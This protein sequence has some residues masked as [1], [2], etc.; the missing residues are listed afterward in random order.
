LVRRDDTLSLAGI[1]HHEAPGSSPQGQ[2]L[3]SLALRVVS[4][5]SLLEALKA[6]IRDLDAE[7][8]VTTA[9]CPREAAR[10]GEACPRGPDSSV[11]EEAVWW[12]LAVLLEA[13]FH[14]VKNPAYF[15]PHFRIGERAGRI[16]ERAG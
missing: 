15:F 14:V 13:R 9:L 12:H 3:A 5:T 6:D 16:V 1:W 2:F 7:P 10:C 8:G 11:G 4:G